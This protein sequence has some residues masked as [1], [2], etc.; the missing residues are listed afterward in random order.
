MRFV[1]V[2]KK[3]R[4]ETAEDRLC[5]IDGTGVADDSESDGFVGRND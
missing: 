5:K 4:S 1:A 2:E 3:S